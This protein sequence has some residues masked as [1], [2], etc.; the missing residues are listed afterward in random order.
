M[1]V[2][3][4]DFACMAAGCMLV[5]VVV[6]DAVWVLRVLSGGRHKCGHRALPAWPT[7]V[8]GMAG[9]YRSRWGRRWLG[10]RVWA[11]GWGRGGVG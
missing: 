10:S 9:L 1:G 11:R 5:V 4:P 3:P 6:M 8:P 2:L 7:P